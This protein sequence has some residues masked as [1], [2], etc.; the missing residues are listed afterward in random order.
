[1]DN[2]TASAQNISDGSIVCYTPTMTTTNG[3]WQGDNPLDFSLPLFILQ[4]TLIVCATR[5]FVLILGPFHQ[6]RVIAEIMGGLLLG[7]SVLGRNAS[8]VSTVFPQKSLLV[9]ET[10]ANIGLIYFLFLVGLEMDISIIKRSGKKT[11]SIALAGM[12]LPFMVG[13]CLSSF[14]Y[15]K[16]KNLNQGGYVLYLGIVLSVTAFP[17]LARMLADLKLINTDLGRLALS[18]SLINDVLAWVLLAVAIALSEQNTSAWASAWVILSNLVFVLFC[19]VA[20]RP[21][22]LWLIKKTPEEKPFSEFQICIVLVGVMISAFVTDVL[23][24]HSVFGAFVYGLTIPNGPLGAAIIEKL[25]DFVSGLLLP[26]FY[27]ISGL[28]T[29][30]KLIN[31][32]SAWTF[33]L[34][35]IPFTCIGKIVGTLLMTLVFQIPNRDGVVLGLLM[36]TKGLI[37]MIVLNVGREQKVLSDEVFSIMVIVTLVMTAIISPIVTIIYKPTKRLIS[38][39]RRT[40]QNSRLDTDLR[41]LLCVHAPRNVPTI[42]NLLEATHPHKRSPICAYVLHLVELTGRA[43]AMLVVHAN[44]QSGGPALNKTQ[45][46][47]D[48]IMTAFRN[49][50]ELTGHVSVHPLTAISPYST[51]HEDICNVAEEKRVSTIIIPFHKQ[52]TVDGEMQD[53]NPALRLVNHNLLQTSPCSVGILVDRGLNG[54]NR[55]TS[56]QASHQ[57]AV[58]YFGGPDDREALAYGWRMSRHPRV[59]LTVMHFI[60]SKDVSKS[61]SSKDDEIDTNISSEMEIKLDE[62]YINEFKTMATKDDSVVYIDKVVSNG[63][64]TV[65]AIRSMNNVND[66][67]IVGRGQGTTSPLKD[68]LTDWSECPELGAIGDLLASSDFETTASVLVMH[69]YVAQGPDGEDIFVAERP[70]QT[71]DNHNNIKQEQIPRYSMPNEM[72]PNFL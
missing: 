38:Y 51:M 63:E 68:G 5:F 42:V 4:L 71:G 37:E 11:L 53:T 20:V 30:I 50:E 16:D 32:A 19:F 15:E 6:P 72:D 39:K 12:V 55:L 3:L 29:D 8:F 18:T 25:E 62:E 69:Q 1:M 17:V 54:S 34:V 52:H 43:S 56:D 27:V 58:L 26:L 60:P 36:N 22:V 24:T 10:M 13:A 44:R 49:F 70:W 65:A 48:H 14:V 33:V 23:G 40:V 41:V 66:L 64:E 2:T 9:M 45:A 28:K 7:P 46:Q 21:A 47:S 59:K 35:L 67:F 57:V 31:G 61:F